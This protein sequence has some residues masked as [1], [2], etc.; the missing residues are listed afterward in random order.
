M[1]QLIGHK[2]LQFISIIHDVRITFH[3]LCFLIVHLI[4][5]IS[6]L[7]VRAAALEG[8]AHSSSWACSP[9]PPLFQEQKHDLQRAP[10][11]RGVGSDDRWPAGWGMATDEVGMAGTARALAPGVVSSARPVLRRLTD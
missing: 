4:V 2:H 3:V 6:L 1:K 5:L 7:P 9:C 10:T 8:Y 11:T